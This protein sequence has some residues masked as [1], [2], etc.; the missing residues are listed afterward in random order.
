MFKPK[1]KHII[2]NNNYIY[3]YIFKMVNTFERSKNRLS[4]FKI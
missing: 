2:I 3:A 4:T 1:L